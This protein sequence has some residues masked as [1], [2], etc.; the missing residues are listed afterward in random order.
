MSASAERQVEIM[1]DLMSMIGTVKTY[2]ILSKDGETLTR[3]YG[4]D[5]L[6]TV[7]Q[8]IADKLQERVLISGLNEEMLTPV[9]P[10]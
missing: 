1:S 6:F 5:I 3:C 9:Y 2:E 7:A 10:Q 8:A 4:E